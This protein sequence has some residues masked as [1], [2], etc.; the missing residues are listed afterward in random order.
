MYC[1]VPVKET[2]G[3]RSI[4]DFLMCYSLFESQIYLGKTQELKGQKRSNI[5]FEMICKP[6]FEVVKVVS[7]LSWSKHCTKIG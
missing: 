7:P 3:R 5:S 6:L 2:C 1:R 4:H